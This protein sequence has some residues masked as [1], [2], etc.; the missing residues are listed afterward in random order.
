LCPDDTTLGDG[1]SR[2][3]TFKKDSAIDFSSDED[4]E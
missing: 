2:N 3:L 4:T 1:E